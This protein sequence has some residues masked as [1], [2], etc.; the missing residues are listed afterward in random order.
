MLERQAA[1]LRP[2]H[3]P[4]ALGFLAAGPWDESSL[5]DIREASRH[6]D[7]SRPEPAE[8]KEPVA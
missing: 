4:I 8:S 2:A 5:R 6:H 7:T 3:A 1:L